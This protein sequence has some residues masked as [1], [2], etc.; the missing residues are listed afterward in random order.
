MNEELKKE[1]EEH[2]EAYDEVKNSEDYKKIDALRVLA[3]GALAIFDLG[4]ILG[5]GEMAKKVLETP[6]NCGGH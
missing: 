3:P 5:K 2:A 4:V 1:L 6:C